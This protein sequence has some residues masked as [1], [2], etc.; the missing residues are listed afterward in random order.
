[1]LDYTIGEVLSTKCGDGK[2]RPV[3]FISKTLNTMKQNYEIH[4]KEILVV[5]Q[6]LKA[7]RYYLKKVKMEFE[8]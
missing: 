6:C 2:W 1:M 4:N 5:I 8:I 3:A 7:W